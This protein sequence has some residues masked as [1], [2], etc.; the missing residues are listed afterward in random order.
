M[1]NK[2][3]LPRQRALRGS[4]RFRREAACPVAVVRDWRSAR[5]IR[6]VRRAGDACHIGGSCVTPTPWQ[7][8]AQRLHW[9]SAS[10][11]AALAVIFL[12]TSPA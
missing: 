11:T 6:H 8:A 10:A 4:G 5:W 12:A 7:Q 2:S 1:R 3:S 9:C